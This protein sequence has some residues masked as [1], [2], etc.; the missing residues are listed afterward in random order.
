MVLIAGRDTQIEIES[1]DFADRTLCSY[2]VA[3]PISAGFGDLLTVTFPLV[4]NA[5][6]SYA[7]GVSFVEASSQESDE[8][9]LIVPTSRKEFKTYFPSSMYVT[10]LNTGSP[11]AFAMRFLHSKKSDID[12]A[13][14]ANNNGSPFEDPN[15]GKH[16]SSF[17]NPVST[18][19]RE[20]DPSEVG[21]Y[22]ILIAFGVVLL[23]LFL[24]GIAC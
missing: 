10:V 18:E 24:S 12:E 21:K 19:D 14:T 1:D 20:A 9:E 6:V 16:I 8:V 5:E 4:S 22:A 2:K 17:P 7:H 15:R 3:F 23:I 11:G 13:L